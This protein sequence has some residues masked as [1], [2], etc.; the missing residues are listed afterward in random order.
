MAIRASLLGIS[1]QQTTP[2]R[3]LQ[4]QQILPNAGKLLLRSMTGSLLVGHGMQKLFGVFGGSGI[5]GT[6]KM[7]ESMRLRPGKAWAF[8]GG[9]SEMGGGA[10]M[11]LGFLHPVGPIMTI[12]TMTMAIAKAH[13][14]KPIWAT[15]G[16]GELPLTNISIAAS[17]LLTGP[18]VLSL[19][20]LFGIRLPRWS[21][22]IS[23]L[24]VA[25]TVACGLWKSRPTTSAEESN[26]RE[27]TRPTTVTGWR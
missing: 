19:D 5:A 26:V 27:S 12:G 10:L 4:P 13:W 20:R 17:Q 14:G 24:A 7:F 6:S 11:G 8:L 1:S 22:P 15:Q 18:G 21:Y 9:T 25:G 23:A 2:Q 3:A 16:G